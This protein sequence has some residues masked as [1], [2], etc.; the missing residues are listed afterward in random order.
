MKLRNIIWSV[1]GVGLLIY[2]LS[3]LGIKDI[4]TLF[5]NFDPI[6]L[7]PYLAVSVLIFLGL[8]LRWSV[9]LSIY[10]KN[11]SFKDLILYKMAGYF[12]SY[13]TPSAKIGGEGVRIYFLM[14]EKGIDFD[15]ATTSVII[16]KII[17]LNTNALF[18]FV[19]I[20]LFL[21]NFSLPANLQWILVGIMGIIAFFI[22]IYYYRIFHNKPV[23]YPVM[24]FLHL[25]RLKVVRRNEIKLKESEKKMILFHIEHRGAFIFS[26]AL[27]F[28]LLFLSIIEFKFLSLLFGYHLSYYNIF[29]IL[30]F[31]GIAY[32]LPVPGALGVL[33]GGQVWF[34]DLLGLGSKVGFGIAILTRI[35]DTLWSLGGLIYLYAKGIRYGDFLKKQPSTGLIISPRVQEFKKWKVK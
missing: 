20:F 8:V 3:Q 19:G 12:I 10:H 30:M 24:R 6:Y 11:N 29:Y 33:E 5:T 25:D 34:S 13:I 2:V 22:F 32:I 17:E 26:L 27:S 23:F 9:I 35:R 31:V 21:F 14:K 4:T 28:A 16:D 7:I 18:T 15:R 1:L